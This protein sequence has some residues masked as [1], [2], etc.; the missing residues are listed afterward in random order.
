MARTTK[1][2]TRAI[3]GHLMWTRSGRVWATWRLSAQPYGFRPVKDKE[4]VR[5]WH[6]A[7]I[8]ALPGESL[9]LGVCTDTDPL[10]VV[11]RMI[12]G[13][14][15]A[16]HPAWAAECE[17]T[18]DSLEDIRIG[19]RAYWLAVPL[20][21]RPWDD[22]RTAATWSLRDKLG[23]ARNRTPREEVDRRLAQARAVQK[24][25]PSVFL[26]TPATPAQLVWLHHHAQQRGLGA[27]LPLPTAPDGGLTDQLLLPRS[28]AAM[29]EPLLDEGGQSDHQSGGLAQLARRAN[30][31]ASRFLK[32]VQPHHVTPRRGRLATSTDLT[33]D[34][35]DY[36]PVASY[37]VLLA[38]ADVPS[39][40]MAFPGSEFLGRIDESGI[41][42]DWAIR[43]EVR[44]AQQVD[45]KNRRAL[46]NL[47]EQYSQR[48]GELSH[49]LNELDRAASDLAEYAAVLSSDK[50]EVET[51]ATIVFAVAAPTAEGAQ[52]KARSLSAYFADAGYRLAVPLGGQSDLWWSMIPGAPVNQLVRDYAQ[53]T[54]SHAFAATVPLASTALGDRKGSLLAVNPSSGLGSAVFHDIADASYR[55][56]SGALALG[57]ELGSGKTATMKKLA[58][59]SVDRGGQ[60]IAIDRTHVGEWVAWAK[61]VTDTYEVDVANP[62]YSLDPLR[63]H[64]LVEGSQ[65]AQSFFTRLLGIDPKSEDG[66]VLADVLEPT[67]LER[68]DLPSIAALLDHLRSGGCDLRDVP[69]AVEIGQ[70]IAGKMRVF[71]RKD[72]GDVLF[73]AAIPAVDPT[74]SAIVIRTA[75]V[76]LPRPGE[77]EADHLF[78]EMVPEKI[79]GRAL[80]ALIV[81]LARRI[82]FADPTRLGMFCVP[83]AHHVTSSPEGQHELI[84]FVRDGRK[85]SA[86]VVLDSHDPL[87]DFGSETLRGLIPTRILMRQTDETLARNG[88]RWLGLDSEDAALLDELMTDVSP[89]TAHGVEEWRRGEAFMRDANGNIGRI[90]VLL[91][92]LADRQAAAKSTPLEHRLPAGQEDQA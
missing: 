23:L 65:V 62:R 81:G 40:G 5:R 8:R 50:N 6:Q 7:L 36:A 27:E 47:N 54:T 58:G 29:T 49:G 35:S 83:E 33:D 75:S 63:V 76:Q 22:A 19:D 17:A 70:K 48:A 52:D 82:C 24:V 38:L 20:P 56:T 74:A 64:G 91:P 67:Y 34:T 92:A 43:M 21:S 72:F 68:H 39:E 55:D 46:V 86:A 11:E 1:S 18:L 79:F 45:R 15:L 51:Q 31:L 53:I 71:A 12:E 26:P 14:D 87:A 41:D 78:K 30:P 61:S 89:K 4:D 69:G 44:A 60:V 25:I 88:L 57:G 80:Y 3:A 16:E 66:T 32:V 13:I 84:E 10:A 77:L 28:G 73:N 85:H 90:K 42:V 59:D 9:L 2:P 37:Q